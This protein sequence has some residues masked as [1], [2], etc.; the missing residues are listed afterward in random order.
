MLINTL[1]IMEARPNSEIENVVTT[2]DKIFQF[3]QLETEE[4]DSTTKE[5]LQYRTALFLGFVS[6]KDS[7]LYTQT[8]VLVCSEIKGLEMDIRK[9]TG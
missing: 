7:P 4:Q 3:L 1:P 6:L 9:V 2:T 5:A 8:V